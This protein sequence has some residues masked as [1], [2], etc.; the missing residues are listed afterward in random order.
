MKHATHLALISCLAVLLAGCGNEAVYTGE[1][2]ATDS[3]FKLKVDD[4]VTVACESARRSLL[5]Q[6]Y[7]IDSAAGEQVKG[8]KAYRSADNLNTFIEMNVVCVPDRKGSTLYTNG[9][10]STYDLKK[11]GNSASVGIS[12]VGSIS[13]P[14]G[15]SADSLVKIAEETIEDKAFYARFFAAVGH[16]LQEMETRPE[17]EP[18]AT[19]PAKGAPEADIAPE[20]GPVAPVTIAPEPGPALPAASA[21][22]ASGSPAVAE[23]AAT[24]S[25]ATPAAAP[26]PVQ[27]FSVAAPQNAPAPAT[28]PV[29]TADTAAPASIP[30]ATPASSPAAVPASTPT[31]APASTPAAAPA[32]QPI[33]PAPQQAPV[34]SAATATAPAPTVAIPA[35]ATVSAPAAAAP[36][37]TPAATQPAPVTQP[38]PAPTQDSSAT[39][40]T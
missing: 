18:A 36:A 8:R 2:F 6:G 39:P 19:E 24:A 40:P 25:A 38:A 27:G 21:G 7:L 14:F 3:P 26:G 5:G 32:A 11:S 4:T 20:P 29:P 22:A 15:Q 17:S 12:A 23:P 10:L 30:S 34:P 9:V 35:A 33:S 16:V 28:T 13:L 1:S 37:T 31:A